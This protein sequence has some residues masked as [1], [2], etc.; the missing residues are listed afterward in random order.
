M[1][2]LQK[3]I[4][5]KA[6]NSELKTLIAKVADERKAKEASLAQAQENLRKVLSVRQEA[7]AVVS[8]LLPP[9]AK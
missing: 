8:G 2:E 3:A 6:S 5:G 1:G 4:D 9:S 7:L